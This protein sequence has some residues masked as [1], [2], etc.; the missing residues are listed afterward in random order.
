MLETEYKRLLTA[1]EYNK[2]AAHF[3]WDSV[4]EQTN[5]YYGDEDKILANNRVMF[6]VRVKGGKSVIQVKLHKNADSPLQICEELEYPIDGVPEV[7]E[8]GEKYTG[9]KTGTLKNLGCTVTLRHSKMWDSQTEICLDK[10]E[11]LGITD[12]EIE[13]E[14]TDEH[15]DSRGIEPLS[16]SALL[17]KSSQK[18]P[19]KLSAELNALGVEFKE[20]SVGKYTRF[21]R[22]LENNN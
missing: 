22:A 5:H 14:Y 21:L 3:D 20:N 9:I 19:E 15:E 18:I 8:N 10:T 17:R 16:S 12:Y 2:I 4:K 11:Y 1:D 7:I 6:R 13:I